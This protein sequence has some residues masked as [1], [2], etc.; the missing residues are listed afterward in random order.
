MKTYVTRQTFT[1]SRKGSKNEN[2][3]DSRW[4]NKINYLKKNE[5]KKR[6]TLGRRKCGNV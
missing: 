2:K 4:P 5:N 1:S 3:K 6:I